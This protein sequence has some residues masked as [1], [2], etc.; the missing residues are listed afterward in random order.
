MFAVY[1][2]GK[3]CIDVGLSVHK[4]W[5]NNEFETLEE[6]REYAK[7]WLGSN[8][9]GV[10]LDVGEVH[11]YNGQGD[12]IEIRE[13]IDFDAEEIVGWLSDLKQRQLEALLLAV[14]LQLTTRADPRQEELYDS[15][16][17]YLEKRVLQ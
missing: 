13:I 12:T 4:D 14:A 16:Y 7:D 5:S 9:G 1:E 2:N 17:D 11:D 10:V 3:P 15:I 8:Y 6:A